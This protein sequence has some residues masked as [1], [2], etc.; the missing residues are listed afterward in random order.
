MS[1][2]VASR[3]NS[4]HV[5]KA[6]AYIHLPKS[7]DFGLRHN[8]DATRAGGGRLFRRRSK[9]HR[10]VKVKLARTGTAVRKL[11]GFKVYNVASYLDRGVKLQTAEQLPRRSPNNSS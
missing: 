7:R 3:G 9:R 8:S 11:A 10:G 5:C 1:F 6:I 2:P 4:H